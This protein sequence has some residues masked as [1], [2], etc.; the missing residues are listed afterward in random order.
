MELKD[1]LELIE[2]KITDGS[3]YEWPCYPNGRYFDS[4][5]GQG[6]NP[7]VSACVIFSTVD[8]TVY[9]ATVCDELNDRCYRWINPDFKDA[10]YAEA[11]KRNCNPN[12]A[13]DDVDFIDLDVE[14][15][16]FE[17]ASAILAGE[18]YDDRVIMEVDLP[19][20][21]MFKAMLAAHIED[22]TLNEFLANAIHT[23]L[24]RLKTEEGLAEFQREY[25]TKNPPNYEI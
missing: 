25:Q 13:W 6:T 23:G 9:E 20:D 14:R 2:Y 1:F 17:K 16:F 15:D 10:Y 12:T 8:Q 24:E 5:T 4:Y 7:Q 21:V 3:A 19:H 18:E 11:K 22:I